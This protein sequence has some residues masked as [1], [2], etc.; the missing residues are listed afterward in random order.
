MLAI[1]RA[2]KRLDRKHQLRRN[3]GRQYPPEIDRVETIDV[4]LKTWS[5]LHT[6]NNP[7]SSRQDFVKLLDWLVSSRPVNNVPVGEKTFT[8]PSLESN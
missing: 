2:K 5:A 8:P 4:D 7:S 1:D 3:V 6:S